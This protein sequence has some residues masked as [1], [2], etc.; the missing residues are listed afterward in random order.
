MTHR[1]GSWPLLLT[2]LPA[3]VT[4][5]SQPEKDT[6]P[7]GSIDEA[8]S[9][10]ARLAP[11]AS[12]EAVQTLTGNNAAF[13]LDLLHAVRPS[14]NFFFSPHSLSVALGM[15]YAGARTDTQRE[16]AGVLHFTQ[17]D[18]ELHAAFNTLDQELAS[19]GKDAKGADGQPFRLRLANAAWVQ[20][21]SSFLPEYLDTLAR[22]YGAGVKLQDFITD[23]EGARLTINAW[24]DEQTEGKIPELL[25]RGSLNPLTR[26]VL[27]NT[28]YF[29]A[30][31]QTPFEP[32]A[33][34]PGAF[35]KLDG[36]EVSVPLMQGTVTSWWAEGAGW[37]ATS[38][39]Y[40]GQEV[41]LIA[42]L[43]EAGTFQQFEQALD[44]GKLQEIF[45]AL[46]SGYSVSVKLPRFEFR[47][48]VALADALSA[49][50]MP[51]A[52]S[53]AADFSGIDGQ[54]D[55]HLQQVVHEAYVKVNEAGTEAAAA[56]AV[57]GGTTGVPEPRAFEATRPFLFAV[58]DRA[59]GAVVFLGR[60]VDPS[61]S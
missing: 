9:D 49:M 14:G 36:A 39:P 58:R 28:V 23:S 53:D 37:Q 19:R 47:S 31:W 34:A 2:L 12:S 61:A 56:T 44:A 15:T 11:E 25:D 29:N 10:A 1:F 16:M 51:T 54:R 32:E 45:G 5:C 20:Q 26:F 59:T 13:A 55:L 33:T 42:I 21:D 3:L 43:P 41:E 6:S 30:S 60:V 48:K 24:V 4:G 38:L 8:R 40:D 35:T 46:R 57:I 7:Q 22:Y 17:P 27:T 52:F 18:A 50:G